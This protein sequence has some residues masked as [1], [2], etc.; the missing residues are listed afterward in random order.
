MSINSGFM[1]GADGFL[2]TVFTDF[3]PGLAAIVGG[4]FIYAGAMKVGDPAVFARDV[5]NFHILPWSAGVLL[6]VYLPWLEIIAGGA[7][8]L[9]WMRSGAIAILG[10]LTTVFI[11]AT[12]VAQLRGIDVNCGCFGA[13][14]A[15][16]SF[17]THLALDIALLLVILWLARW[18]FSRHR[19][20]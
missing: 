10:G 11:I 18:D 16:W 14:T 6:A 17:A 2:R 5:S 20:G 15:N 9:G 19:A 4:L 12:V 8:F 3:R 1:R 13:A 7:M